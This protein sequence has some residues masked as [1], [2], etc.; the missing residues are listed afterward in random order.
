MHWTGRTGDN[1]RE[2][3]PRTDAA[4]EDIRVLDRVRLALLRGKDDIDSSACTGDSAKSDRASEDVTASRSRRKDAPIGRIIAIEAALPA[5][6]RCTAAVG[7]CRPGRG[8]GVTD[9]VYQDKG[10]KTS[11]GTVSFLNGIW[12]VEFYAGAGVL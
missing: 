12:S 9:F 5:L 3:W 7:S 10:H 2:D 8:V 4:D 11:V 1:I 6:D